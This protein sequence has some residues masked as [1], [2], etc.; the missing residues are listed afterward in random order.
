MEKRVGNPSLLVFCKTHQRNEP[1]QQWLDERSHRS[2]EAQVKWRKEHKQSNKEYMK[3]YRKKVRE[4]QLEGQFCAECG[5]I[6]G[7]RIT[8]IGVLCP[9]CHR[10]AFGKEY[11]SRLT[12]IGIDEPDK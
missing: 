7:L 9:K 6:S 1:E 4:K 8:G 10:K 11:C 5:K 2:L 3:A 12:Q